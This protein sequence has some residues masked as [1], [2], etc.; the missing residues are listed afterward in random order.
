[1][2]SNNNNKV[3]GFHS[4]SPLT[5]SIYSIDSFPT[6]FSGDL[7]E[8]LDAA[9]AVVSLRG[10][11]GHVVPL[12]GCDDVHHGLG[13]VRVWR[14]HAGEEV[15]AGVVAQLGRRGGVADLRDLDETREEQT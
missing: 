13:L 4:H 1:M 5:S 7:D 6:C 2:L 8:G 12:H 9:L 10:E 3:R 11:R 15:I 14:H